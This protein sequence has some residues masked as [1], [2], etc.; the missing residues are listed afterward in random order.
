MIA[1]PKIGWVDFPQQKILPKLST[2]P[3]DI[4]IKIQY[5]KVSEIL[6][7]KEQKVYKSKFFAGIL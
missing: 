1:N 5:L 7:E 4:G 6:K 3:A 2:N